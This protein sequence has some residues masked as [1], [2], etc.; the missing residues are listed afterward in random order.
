[1]RRFSALALALSVTSVAVL[2]ASPSPSLRG[3]PAAMQQQN[4]VARQHGLT[5]YRTPAEI[6]Q[7]VA[8]GDLVKLEGNE[9]YAVADFVRFPY[10]QPEGVLFIERL[11]EQYRDACGQ[12]LVVTSAVRPSN[13]QPSNAHRLSVHP[14]GMAVDLRV[15]DRASCRSWLETALMNLERRG[16][17]N[18]IREF[19]PPHYHVAIFPG[20]YREYVEERLAVELERAAEEAAREAEKRVIAKVPDGLPG[21]AHLTAP[22]VEAEPGEEGETETRSPLWVALAIALTLPVGLGVLA[23]R[24]WRRGAADED[25]DA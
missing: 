20:P 17:L 10:L 22:A 1:M 12:K 16:V 21:V 14:A 8:D 3:S 7:A 2:E 5:F 24:A 4:Q 15:S 11:S 18:G 23:R 25:N 9:N 19:R 13:G 6:R